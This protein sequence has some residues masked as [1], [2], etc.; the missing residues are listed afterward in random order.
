M[1]NLFHTEVSEYELQEVITPVLRSGQFVIGPEIQAFERDLSLYLGG[2]D[3]VGCGSGTDALILA[4]ETFQAKDWAWIVPAMTFSATAEAVIRAGG[5]PLVCDV[6]QETLTP[7]LQDVRECLAEAIYAGYPVAGVILV[8]L[9]GWPAYDTV[10]IAQFCKVNDLTLIEDCAQAFGAMM[11]G[12][13]VGNFG[14][15]AAFSFYP[16]KSL[17][18]IGDAGAVYFRDNPLAAA[19]V[20]AMRNHGRTPNGQTMAGFNS[21]IDE[22]N[23]AL[24]RYRL[25]RYDDYNVAIRREM[26]GRY[27]VN[28]VKKL[29]LRRAGR[30]VPYVYPIL[31]GERE[32]AMF[33]L[34]EL[35]I[36]T[37][38]HYC[39]HVGNLPYIKATCPMADYAEK[40]IVTLPCHHGMTHGDVDRISDVL[41]VKTTV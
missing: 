30:G 28:G 33:A 3:A 23:A 10:E 14:D 18:G 9:Y 38:T 26:S 4:L 7:S 5:I 22:P 13:K 25:G 40:H 41:R 29:S 36:Q 17:G 19:H 37:G 6:D 32:K 24:L 31:I 8:H 1:L 34:A 16:T 27:H 39:P 21:R 20:A 11:D 2:G 15:A 35:G 12:H